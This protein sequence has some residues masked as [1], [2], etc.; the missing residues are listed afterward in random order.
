LFNKKSKQRNSKNKNKILV[1]VP[2]IMEWESPL[3]LNILEY[4]LNGRVKR[5]LIENNLFLSD[6]ST[7]GF[8]KRV[9]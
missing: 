8:M 1:I 9:A 4:S 5:P 3:C 2:K 7:S 6:I